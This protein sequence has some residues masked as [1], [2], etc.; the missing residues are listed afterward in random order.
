MLVLL[1]FVSRFLRIYTNSRLFEE[2]SKNRANERS[3]SLSIAIRIQGN[4][5]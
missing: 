1:S 2:Y 3:I 4:E 5:G